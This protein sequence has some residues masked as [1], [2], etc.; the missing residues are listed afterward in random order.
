MILAFL[1]FRVQN[2]HQI[3]AREY[4]RCGC[5]QPEKFTQSID[6]PQHIN[7]ICIKDYFVINSSDSLVEFSSR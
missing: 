2:I 1:N 7:A 4:I 3:E 5:Y 6:F